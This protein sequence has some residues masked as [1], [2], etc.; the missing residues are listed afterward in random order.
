MSAT[1]AP[2]LTWT[3]RVRRRRARVP[4]VLQLEA[5]E[6]GAASLAMV[7]ARYGAWVPLEELRIA[8]GV[9]RDGANALNILVSARR[10]GLEARGFKR[11]LNQLVDE[12]FPVI[13]FWGFNHFVV[14]EGVSRKGL[15]LND[16]AIGRRLATWEE[17]D[18]KFTGVVLQFARG[19]QFKARGR[20][21]SALRGLLPLAA[22][23]WS[24]VVYAVVAG[25]GLLAPAV[26]IVAVTDL[27]VDEALSGPG[28][29]AWA[30][31]LAVALAIA[32]LLQWYLLR[33][34]QLVSL[35]FNVKLGLL[36]ADRLVGR[37][38]RLPR[39][40]FDQRYAG[41][42]AYRVTLAS[43]V[44]AA[45]SGQLAPALLAML[46]SLIYLALLAVLSLALAGVALLG[47]LANGLALWLAQRKR[48]E[49]SLRST[50]EQTLF[51]GVVAYGL[52]SIDTV[53]ATGAEGDLFSSVA[54]VHA[55]VINSWND[56]QRPT[57]ILA[58]MPGFIGQATT[59]AL[60]GV[61]A[62]LAIDGHLSEGALLA[63]TVALAG[64]LAPITTIVNLGSTMQQLR[65]NLI[66]IED[67]LE[68]PE[69][70]VLAGAMRNGNHRGAHRPVKLRGELELRG[71]TFG[72][73]MVAPPLIKDFDLHLQPGSRAAVVGITGS[74][75]STVARL[76]SGLL[77]P[78]E[79][80]V[81]LDGV[82]YLEWPR[83]TVTGSLAM[84]DQE[85]VMF[86]ATVRD[87]LTLWDRSVRDEDV[88]AAAS[89][90]AIHEQIIRRPDGY[91]AIIEAAGRNWSGGERQRMEIARAL[92]TNPSIV[93]LD[94]A[95]S[96][97]DAVVELQI[98]HALRR[99]A[100]TSVVV[101]HRLSTIR[102][103]DEIV[104]LDRGAVVERGTHEQLLRLDGHYA[105]LVSAG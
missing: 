2:D 54:G 65:A 7:L 77:L 50:K 36:L 4:T 90:A 45:L 44:A 104:V 26:A 61:G 98:D 24:A 55:R 15:L 60:L 103:A 31:G 39:V 46:T 100:C 52:Q 13:A 32:V 83:A 16:P 21:P 97:L 74:G 67:L 87:N 22:G 57:I 48:V 66:R 89:D 78:W 63:S 6:C 80:E 27:Y 92:A 47:G 58:S 71:V 29:D 11:E 38:L 91:E 56:F 73:S 33:L 94:E 72:Y 5:T 81:L 10:Y 20:P 34:Q 93:V 84:V 37:A 42:V 17:A 68:Q 30:I 53:K 14:I 105:T 41:D 3:R 8:A 12:P 28:A 88:V 69:D 96:A 95:T 25:I 59:L 35:R 49:L 9:S 18:A 85:I 19:P 101:A 82:P 51:N 62:L 79:G 86:A 43:Q 40:F 70:P 99:R 75:K 76:I 1:S 64:F 102:D 23:S